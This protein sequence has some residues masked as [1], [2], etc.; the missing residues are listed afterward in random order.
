MSSIKEGWPIK[1]HR[2]ID[3]PEPQQV[4]DMNGRGWYTNI[5]LFI[6][7]H[8]VFRCYI[9]IVKYYAGHLRVYREKFSAVVV[10]PTR[11]FVNVIRGWYVYS[12]SGPK[13]R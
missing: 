2:Y 1:V 9:W 4:E 11:A 10:P 8:R 7:Y 12:L 3:F 5:H 6:D 13:A